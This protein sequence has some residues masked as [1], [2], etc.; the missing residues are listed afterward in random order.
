MT[1]IEQRTWGFLPS[2]PALEDRVYASVMQANDRPDRVDLI[3]KFQNAV[4]DQKRTGSCV[5]NACVSALEYLIALDH[6]GEDNYPYPELSR[7][8]SYWYARAR[9]GLQ[10]V[11]QGSIIRDCVDSMRADGVC[12]EA[13][14]PFMVSKVNNKPSALSAKEASRNRVGIASRV[15]GLDGMIDCLAQGYPFVFGFMVYQGSMDEAGRTGRMPMPKGS[16]FGGHA[17]CV[18][19]YDL[20]SRV[21]IIRNSWG[22]RWGNNGYCTMPFE[23]VASPQLSSDHWTLRSF[24]G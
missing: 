11:D 18:V 7:M 3:P 6:Q 1:K 13:L 19:G 24:G 22:S 16:R 21:F 14:W 20:P 4:E 9:R 23:Y 5:A 15:I 17:V 8:F 10:T 12:E 2:V